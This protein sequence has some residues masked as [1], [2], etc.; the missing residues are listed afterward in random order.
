MSQ[1][2]DC[3]SCGPAPV[4]PFPASRLLPKAVALVG[5]PNSGKTTMFNRLT[6]MRQKVANFPGV[7]VEQHTGI[8]EMPDGRAIRIIDLPGIYSLQPRSEDE[9]IAH[10]VLTGARSDT[11]K[12]EA[13]LLVLDSTNLQRHLMLAAP[14]LSLGLPTLIILNMADDLRN[15]G[16]SLDLTA[17][18]LQLG[19]P[20][21][22]VSA[23]QGQGI[24]QVW[25]FLAGAMPKPAPIELPILQDVPKC[26]QW[27][28]RVGHEANYHPPAPPKWTRR[29]DAL[30]LHP[31]AGPLVF[32]AVVVLVFQTIFSY[33]KPLIDGVGWLFDVSGS[34]LAGLVPVPFLHSLIIVVWAKGLGSVMQFLPQV[35]LLYFFIG[36]LEDSG[37]LARAA[38]IADRTMAR[39]GLQG[40]SFIPLLS[41]HA[42]AVPA[43]MATRVIENKRD[44]LAT[45]LVAPF[46][47]CSARLLPYSIIIAAFIPN[48]PILGNFFSADTAAMLGLYVLGFTAAVITARILKSS[49]LKSARTPFVLEMPA[50]RW[51]TFQS[52]GLRLL[53]RTKVFLFRV[54]GVILATTAIVFLLCQVPTVNGHAPKIENSFVGTLGR[55]IE[56]AIK[57]LGFNWRIGIGLITAVAQ[58][59]TLTSTMGSIYGL[60]ESDKKGLREALR[61]DLSPAAAFALLVFFALAMQCVSTLA[62]VRRETG[63]WKWPAAQFAYMTTLAYVC[64]FVTYHIAR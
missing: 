64:A 29:L 25:D 22:L 41:A 2:S 10:D 33:S 8:A 50:Y 9:Q 20:V 11:D 24:G 21:A 26:R 34:W 58:R 23:R 38:L 15:R 60:E 39:F 5:P 42:C 63:T 55:T 30:F 17:L 37:Y 52:I 32:A 46:M 16:G 53:D 48:R 7:T 49:I 1:C 31:V 47:T 18:Q 13:I 44:R 43:I 6:G 4:L 54:G 59:E 40:K 45:I 62:V 57:P 56:P 27:A 3:D 51:P 14:I 19:A 28:G 12:P 36:I 61:Q 35:L